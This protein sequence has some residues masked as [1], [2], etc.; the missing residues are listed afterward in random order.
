MAESLIAE[1]A[2]AGG[3]IPDDIRGRRLGNWRVTESIARGAMAAVFHGERADGAYEQH[4]AIKLLQP[5]PFRH[6][7]GEQ[8]REELRLLARLE[9]PGIARLLD[10]GISEQ[11]WPYLVMEYVDGVQID[12]WC[13]AQKPDWRQRVQLILKVCDAVRYAHSKL[14][15]HADIKPSNVLVNRDGEPKLVDF[16]IAGLLHNNPDSGQPAASALLRCSP[17]YAAPEQLRGEPVST[18]NDVF[19]LGALL[20][21]LLTGK[22]IRDGK[23]VTALLLGRAP[24]DQIT[25]PC[26]L[27]GGNLP[28]GSSGKD[29]NAICLHAL[30]QDPQQRYGS[31]TELR[32]DLR[33]T[34][35]RYPVAARANTAL[36]RFN[37]WLRR[38]WVAG[39]AASAVVIALTIGL[40]IAMHQAHVARSESQLSHATEKFMLDMFATVDPWENQR[41]PVT[42]DSILDQAVADLPEQLTEFPEQRARIMLTLGDLLNRM[43]KHETALSLGQQALKINLNSGQAQQQLQAHTLIIRTAMSMVQMDLAEEHI[44]TGLALAAF[45]PETTVEADF[46]LQRSQWLGYNGEIEKQHELINALIAAQDDI[47]LLEDNHR[48]VAET[49]MV[50]AESAEIRAD[51][52]RAVDFA[53]MAVISARQVYGKEHL[54]VASALSYEATAEFERGNIGVALDIFDRIGVIEAKYLAPEHAQRVWTAY[55][56]SG[57]LQDAGRIDEARLQLERL[58]ENLETHYSVDDPR[59]GVIYASLGKC[60]RLLGDLQQ[61]RYY[62]EKGMSLT[63]TSEPDNPK[64]GVFYS[65]YAQVLSELGTDELAEQYFLSALKI[66][67]E[68]LGEEHPRFAIASILFADHL[69]RNGR[70]EEA[71]IHVKQNLAVIEQTFP[72]YDLRIAQALAI[73]GLIELRIH[74]RDENAEVVQLHEMVQTILDNNTENAQQWLD[75]VINRFLQSVE[76]DANAVSL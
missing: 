16:G 51:Y 56:R 19:G 49:F 7:E 28:G 25:P 44:Q 46:H 9:H 73:R 30:A 13:A 21:E 74:Q 23:T 32:Q 47:E 20:Y 66:F 67:Q 71:K 14:V 58:A 72:E 54:M 38:N 45:P 61:A 37:C 39:T 62:Y 36:Y 70:V 24:T 60:W 42:V 63:E 8:L 41:E 33:N 57:I 55:T 76:T 27:A 43:G 59:L 40:L 2:P 1:N 34:L 53:R 12:Q 5:G 29:L 3:K 26:Q 68:K 31:V 4:V 18:G 6:S 50:A 22:R 11:G 65:H 64:L 48:L 10:G 52:Q 35:Q 75:P 17:A 69:L 15:V